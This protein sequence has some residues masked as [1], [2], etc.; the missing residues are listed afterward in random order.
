MIQKLN[1]NTISE[2][3]LN[4]FSMPPHSGFQTATEVSHF[5]DVYYEK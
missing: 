3:E 2:T 1:Q 4:M 5:G